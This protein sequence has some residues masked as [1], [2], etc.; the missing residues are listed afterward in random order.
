MRSVRAGK[1][2]FGADIDLA[3]Y[4]RDRFMQPFC[5][6]GIAVEPAYPLN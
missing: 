3:E 2:P 6:E 1:L 5:I 4:G